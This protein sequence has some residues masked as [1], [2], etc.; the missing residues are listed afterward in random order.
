MHHRERHDGKAGAMAVRGAGGDGATSRRGVL[1]PSTCSRSASDPYPTDR[2]SRG[3][4]IIPGA[5]IDLRTQGHQDDAAL[6]LAT[7]CDPADPGLVDPE[8]DPAD[9][10]HRV[11]L[12]N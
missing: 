6:R 5:T 8:D 11:R 12:P 1:Q 10:N 7:L 4:I 9:L 2:H 3:R